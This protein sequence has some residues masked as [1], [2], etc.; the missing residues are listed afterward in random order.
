MEVL[1]LN[2]N[3]VGVLYSSSRLEALEEVE[4]K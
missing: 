4:G 3:A 1:P 2:R